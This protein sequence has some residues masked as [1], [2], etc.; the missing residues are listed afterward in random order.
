MEGNRGIDLAGLDLDA[1][2]LRTFL[3]PEGLV[4]T[5]I[6]LLPLLAIFFLN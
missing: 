3:Q 5:H 1:L 4:I 2:E 6:F